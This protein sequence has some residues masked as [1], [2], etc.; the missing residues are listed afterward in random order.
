MRTAAGEQSEPGH[1]AG[2]LVEQVVL[3][4]E[5]AAHRGLDHA[6]IFR[7]QAQRPGRDCRD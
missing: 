6:H 4:A 3:A 1:L 7:R 2:G 5:G